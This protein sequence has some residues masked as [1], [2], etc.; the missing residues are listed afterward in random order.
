MQFVKAWSSPPTLSF[1]KLEE[2]FQKVISQ[3]RLA[4]FVVGRHGMRCQVLKA[5]SRLQMENEAMLVVKHSDGTEIEHGTD[6]RS[7]CYHHGGLRFIVV[8]SSA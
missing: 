8:R 3:Q 1:S 4:K 5:M 2:G 7:S 6:F